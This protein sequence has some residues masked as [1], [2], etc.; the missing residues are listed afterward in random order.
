MKRLPLLIL[1]TGIILSIILVQQRG[2]E[3]TGRTALAAE[4]TSTVVYLPTLFNDRNTLFPA[5]LFGMQTYGSTDVNAPY[6]D[7]LMGSQASWVRSS[8]SWQIVEPENT[9]PDQF[10][11][12]YADRSMAVARQD[13]GGLN[14]IAVIADV[15]EWA[16]LNPDRD[17]RPIHPDQVGDFAE[18]VHAT[19]ERY[20]GDGFQDA[21]G[22][23]II[24]HWEIFNEPDGD[25]RWGGYGT[26]YAEMLKVVYPAIKSASPG[27]QVLLGGL[28]YDWF[29]DWP[30]PGPF[31]RDFLRDVLDNGGGAYFDI[32]NF[33]VYPLFGEV[34][35]DSKGTGLTEK[36]AAVRALLAE[37]DLE[38]P[39]VITEAG[40][41]NSTDTGDSPSSNAEQMARLV[42]LFVESH[43]S[44]VKVMIWWMLQDPGFMPDYGLVTNDNPPQAKPAYTAYQTIVS[45][46]EHTSF[47]GRLET[48]ETN[49]DAMMAAYQFNRNGR[50]LYVAWLNPYDFRIPVQGE[51]AVL[52]NTEIHPLTI[53]ASAVNVINPRGIVTATL[54]DS[55]G[56][57][58]ITVDVS[59][60]PKY[61]EVTQK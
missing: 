42:Q 40:W 26:A 57:G 8:V 17:S 28:A 60:D 19:V 56:D 2:Q 3:V 39:V 16:R 6:Y 15:P 31:D 33:H 27:A 59:R 22:R 49:G 48:R 58:L 30:N 41:H 45:M 12:T 52:D 53:A 37:Y 43:A 50:P 18:F 7:Y 46:L 51:T 24:R 14:V 25:I 11:W 38:K 1:A 20:D 21:P 9:T 47:E 4:D 5:P 36:T 54:T 13:K 35:W 61:I 34:E 32:M 44:D 23:P 10:S 55:D 29:D